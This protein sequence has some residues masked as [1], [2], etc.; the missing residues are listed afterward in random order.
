LITG[1]NPRDQVVI[2]AGLGR[3]RGYQKWVPIMAVMRRKLQIG[4]ELQPRA[5]AVKVAKQGY[6][7][8]GGW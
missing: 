6:Q 1:D 2:K 3:Y 4:N 5:A 8:A 7:L